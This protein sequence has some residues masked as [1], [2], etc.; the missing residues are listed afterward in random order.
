M[1]IFKDADPELRMAI[2]FFM[3]FLAIMA[4]CGLYAMH[5]HTEMATEAMKAGL[6][7]QVV[8]TPMGGHEVIWVK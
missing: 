4:A 7:Q 2:I 6:H 5:N 8:P 1:Q 3:V